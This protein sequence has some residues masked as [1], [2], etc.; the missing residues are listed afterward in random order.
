MLL[1]FDSCS[2]SVMFV[3]QIV[4]GYKIRLDLSSGRNRAGGIKGT[5]GT[6][7]NIQTTKYSL[8]VNFNH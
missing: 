1:F 2:L 4:I 8:V 6:Q 7:F 5:P 3:P